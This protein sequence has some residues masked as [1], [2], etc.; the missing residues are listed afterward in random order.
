MS[1]SLSFRWYRLKATVFFWFFYKVRD[2][3]LVMDTHFFKTYRLSPAVFDENTLKMAH[4]LA[5]ASC[6]SSGICASKTWK[7][8]DTVSKKADELASKARQ[9][10]KD[11]DPAAYKEMMSKIQNVRDLTPEEHAASLKAIAEINKLDVDYLPR[12]TDAEI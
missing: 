5:D 3:Y 4:I 10:T 1:L 2:L 9:E 8:S 6:K 12:S 11:A 7:P